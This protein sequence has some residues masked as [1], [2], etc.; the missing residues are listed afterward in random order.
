METF[1]T[2]IPKSIPNIQAAAALISMSILSAERV[3]YWV[4]TEWQVVDLP[5]VVEQSSPVDRL[6]A[7][8]NVEV[9]GVGKIDLIS[10]LAD[11]RV[12][13][14]SIARIEAA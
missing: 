3:S 7:L 8:T 10:A 11:G 2:A 1:A 6:E 12:D 13:P 5:P 9:Q 4:G 14:Y